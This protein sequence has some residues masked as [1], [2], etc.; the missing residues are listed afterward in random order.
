LGAGLVA[1]AQLVTDHDANPDCYADGHTNAYGHC[2]ANAHAV[3]TDANANADRY[4][5]PGRRWR[6]QDRLCVATRRQQ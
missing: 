1:V 5:N 3:Y 4:T 6:R 2:H